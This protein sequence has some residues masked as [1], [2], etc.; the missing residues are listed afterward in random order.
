M[1]PLAP[2]TFSTTTG[3]PHASVNL[4]PSSRDVT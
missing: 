3:L 4:S 1:L 2:V